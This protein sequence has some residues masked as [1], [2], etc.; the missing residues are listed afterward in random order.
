[1]NCN[2]ANSEELN[3]LKL[4]EDDKIYQYWKKSKNP[5]INHRNKNSKNTIKVNSN[6]DHNNNFSIEEITNNNGNVFIKQYNLNKRDMINYLVENKQKYTILID[7]KN[8]FEKEMYNNKQSNI[9]KTFVNKEYKNIGESI[10]RQCY[11]S[12]FNS[13][14][15]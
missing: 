8:L 15:N 6:R 13:K 10:H 1:M 11:Q 5:L 2:T 4:K 12:S 3:K 9:S 14:Y 7:G